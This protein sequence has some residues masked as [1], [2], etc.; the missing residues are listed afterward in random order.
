MK[1][2][3]TQGKINLRNEKEERAGGSWNGIGEGNGTMWDLI[4]KNSDYLEITLKKCNNTHLNHNQWD[5]VDKG[6]E[7]IRVF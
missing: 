3:L 6:G 7:R 1:T 2:R 4:F 5:K